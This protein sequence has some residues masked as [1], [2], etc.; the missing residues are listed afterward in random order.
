[1]NIML[2]SVSER[3]REIGI[4][5][6]IGAKRR[7]IMI[8]FL[9]ESLL[10]TGIGGIIGIILGLLAIK[11]IIGNIGLIQPVYSLPWTIAAF[12]ISLTIGITFG[13]F[14]AYKAA[15]LNPIEALRNE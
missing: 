15:K 4:R 2:V 3:T 9:I 6:A 5:K 13:L 10:L 11:Y 8:Q 12:S 1:M 14:P 7:D